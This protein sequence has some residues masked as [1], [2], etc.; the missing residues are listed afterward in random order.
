MRI[1]LIRHF[2]VD[3]KR[4][5]L[6]TS[7]EY[8]EYMA[9]YDKAGV[10]VNELV[11]DKDWDKCYCSS[12]DRAITTAKTVYHGE[13]II[14]DK[15]MEI[16]ASAFMNTKFPLPYFLWGLL[17]RFAWIRNLV[18]QPEKRQATLKRVNEIVD[19]ILKEESGNILI[20]S[21]AGALHEIRKILI[22]KGF[23]GERFLGARNGKLYVYEN[24]NIR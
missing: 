18:S 14:S 19:T 8:N 9:Q 17:N 3:L 20:V 1:G 23:R 6:M 15:L 21:H 10:I 24:K 16:P 5:K 12:M 2:K 22:Q 13:I 7:K 4:N 11:I